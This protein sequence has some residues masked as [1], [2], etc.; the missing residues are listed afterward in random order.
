MDHAGLIKNVLLLFT[1]DEQIT[2]QIGQ[3]IL[4]STSLDILNGEGLSIFA[5]ILMGWKHEVR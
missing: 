4:S 1:V 5:V 3:K 2:W